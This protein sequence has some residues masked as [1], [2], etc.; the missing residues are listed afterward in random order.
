MTAGRVWG[1]KSG[2]R[3]IAG[4]EQTG[5]TDLLSHDKRCVLA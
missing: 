5:L 3:W 1:G 4:W 2:D